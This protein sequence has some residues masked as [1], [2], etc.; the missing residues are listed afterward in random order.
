MPTD[1]KTIPLQSL[2]PTPRNASLWV[3]FLM[4]LACS[5]S[6]A[7]D[8]AGTASSSNPDGTVVFTIT[9]AKIAGG[10]ISRSRSACFDVSG[11][12]GQPA[13]GSTQNATFVI[14]SGFQVGEG[15]HDSLFR[16]A[17]EDCQP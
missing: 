15:S 17:F 12:A 13:A 1:K 7:A 3:L 6:L 10:G 11:T 4:G 8:P 14:L 16:S 5:A 9:K 2:L